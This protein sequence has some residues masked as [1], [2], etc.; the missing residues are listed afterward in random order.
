MKKYLILLIVSFISG[1]VF[2]SSPESN[3]QIAQAYFDAY[4]ARDWQ[5]L[6]QY[7]DEEGSFADITAKPVFGNV[8]VEGKAQTL[9][10]FTKNYASIKAMSF[11]S[12]RQWMSGDVAIFEGSLNWQISIAENKVVMTTDMPFITILELRDG[13]VFR[14]RDYADYQ[15]FLKAYADMNVTQ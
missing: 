1:K 12:S 8:K 5:T 15:P 7:L 3:L 13:H 14:H 6:G 11:T 2:A 9:A 4:I 10:Y